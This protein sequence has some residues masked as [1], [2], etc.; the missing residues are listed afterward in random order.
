MERKYFEINEKGAK[1]AKEMSSFSDYIV[2]SQTAEYKKQVDSCYDLADKA[3]ERKPE[4]AE[5]I[6]CLSEKYSKKLA[7]YY[8]QEISISIRC[9][10]VM[11]TGSP[12]FPVRKKE[13]QIAAWE[14]NY[15]RYKEIQKIPE[16]IKSIMYGSEIIKSGD[17]NAIEK[18]EQKLASLEKLQENMKQINA[19]YRKH[20]TLDGCDVLEPEQIEKLKE[21][22]AS[23]WRMEPKPFES[24]ALTNNNAC[25][26]STK[27]RLEA[28]K[29]TKARENTETV[30][31]S[32]EMPFKVVE[33]TDLM[34]LQILFD[35]KPGE[36]TRN[37]LK[38]NG[39]KWAPSQSAWQ[40]QLTNNAIYSAKKVIEQLQ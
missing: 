1:Q 31:E 15:K 25:I 39:F 2:G 11:I 36:Q 6:Y 23:S 3:A 29:K 24:F 20:K 22:M 30:I 21:S 13:K 33:N 18:L 5:R 4:E 10:S 16:K 37:I 32:K 26:N 28:L 38:S 17:A 7:E 19:Y 35:E 40:R 34:R 9:P 8:N 14:T 27:K 12:N